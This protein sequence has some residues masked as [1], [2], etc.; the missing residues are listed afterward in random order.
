MGLSYSEDPM[1]VAWVVLTWL[2][3]TDR[4]TDGRTESIIA[5][6]ALCIG[7]YMLTRCQNEFS[8][9]FLPKITKLGLNLSKLCGTYATFTLAFFRTRCVRVFSTVWYPVPV[10]CSHS[11]G[12]E[13]SVTKMQ[14]TLCTMHTHR[15]V[16][17]TMC[18]KQTDLK[19]TT[20]MATCTLCMCAERRS[21]PLCYCQWALPVIQQRRPV[22][23][24]TT[25]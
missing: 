11:S 23:D 2:C 9:W 8:E 15:W 22:M 3:R 5:N 4:Q 7:S 20:L 16:M 21:L 6:T 25:E 19:M 24:G 1:I 13:W 14:G 18:Q 12:K 17:V 10:F